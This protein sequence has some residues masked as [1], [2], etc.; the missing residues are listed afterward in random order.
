MSSIGDVVEPE[1]LDVE[2]FKRVITSERKT[3]T[4][5]ITKLVVTNATSAGDNYCSDIYRANL[6]YDDLESNESNIKLSLIVKSMPELVQRGTVIEDLQLYEKERDIYFDVLPKLS[7]I[8]G[9]EF[10]AAKCYYATKIPFKMV[11]FQ[12]LTSIG[13]Q[14]CDRSELL[15]LKH[16][17]LVLRQLSK[18]HAAS[19][20]YNRDNDQKLAKTYDYGMYNK[21]SKN[22]Q[23]IMHM[24]GQSMVSFI[25]MVKGWNGYGSIIPK[26]ENIQN[27]LDAKFV[28]ATFQ[29]NVTNTFRVLNHGDCW[30]N[31]YMFKYDGE[32][33]KNPQHVVFIDYQIV[34]Y[35]SPGI[36]L[37][38]FFNTSIKL[39]LMRHESFRSNL[40]K[41]Y[42]DSLSENMKK[43]GV[44]LHEIPTVQRIKEEVKNT[45]FYGIY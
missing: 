19:Y 23:V 17:E 44:S 11:V 43:L 34:F 15:D 29:T 38:Y 27:N 12:D 33:L 25:E 42:H 32:N 36:D 14:M 39:E 37:N 22:P 3:S 7:K 16:I 9:G 5:Q 20:V 41:L 21:H 40:I 31:N 45:E 24:F 4:I 13:Y 35:A 6:I 26:L 8:L 1:C 2:F 10:I 18:F 28:E 30:V